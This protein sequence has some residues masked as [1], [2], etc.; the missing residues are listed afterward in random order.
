MNAPNEAHRYFSGVGHFTAPGDPIFPCCA[1][2]PGDPIHLPPEPEVACDCDS[3]G[4]RHYYSPRRCSDPE[5]VP[6]PHWTHP[7]TK[8]TNYPTFSVNGGTS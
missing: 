7:R 3:L 5:I 4:F 2:S 8:P 6:D 1:K